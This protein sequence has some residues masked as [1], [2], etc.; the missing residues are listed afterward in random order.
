MDNS[1]VMKDDDHKPDES[2]PDLLVDAIINATPY[3]KIGLSLFVLMLGLVYSFPKHFLD[4]SLFL[5]CGFLIIS[6][7]IFNFLINKIRIN[8]FQFF[9]GV[10]FCVKGLA[11]IFGYNL[12]FF[13]TLILVIGIFLTA[14][15]I[16]NAFKKRSH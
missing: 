8:Y 10:I 3:G 6:V 11:D 16:G 7:N 5:S 4:G 1:P 12:I 2:L 15:A 14:R 9:F 13:P